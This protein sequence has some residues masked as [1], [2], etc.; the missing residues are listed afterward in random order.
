MADHLP[1]ALH[2]I[3]SISSIFQLSTLAYVVH[4]HLFLCNICIRQMKIKVFMSFKYKLNLF[5]NRLKVLTDREEEQNNRWEKN[6]KKNSNA[7]IYDTSCFYSPLG[8]WLEASLCAPPPILFLP[9]SGKLLLIL[10]SQFR[11]FLGRFGLIIWSY[12]C[13]DSTVYVLNFKKYNQ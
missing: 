13:L 11:R 12:G 7:K 2:L 4:E 5:Y 3:L 10:R 1:H 9:L 6:Y 8:F